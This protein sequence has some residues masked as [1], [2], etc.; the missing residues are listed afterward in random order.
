MAWSRWSWT[1][2]H[3][4]T[5]AGWAALGNK[6]K[7]W[8]HSASQPQQRGAAAV[9][10]SRGSRGFHEPEPDASPSVSHHHQYHHHPRTA[11]LADREELVGYGASTQSRRR[12][13][14]GRV[15]DQRPLLAPAPP[16]LCCTPPRSDR[17]GANRAPPLAFSFQNIPQKP[18]KLI[19]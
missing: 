5:G 14:P 10:Q 19:T 2:R 16:S 18:K 1:A 13:R 15:S 4:R 6:K 12:A 9:T 3:A 11:Q 7:F 17:S 8:E